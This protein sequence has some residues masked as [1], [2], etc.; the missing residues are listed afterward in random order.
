MA[1]PYVV[2]ELV[3]FLRLNA[4]LSLCLFLLHCTSVVIYPSALTVLIVLLSF[5]I[6]KCLS[7]LKIQYPSRLMLNVSSVLYM[8]Y[9]FPWE[10]S[11]GNTLFVS[12]SQP[13]HM[14]VS[15]VLELVGVLGHSY[16]LCV[17]F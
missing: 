13:H 4:C 5:F 11:L 12:F 3:I 7:F 15:D 2:V 14:D 6:A 10:I 8:L 9:C 1:N 16:L 17:S